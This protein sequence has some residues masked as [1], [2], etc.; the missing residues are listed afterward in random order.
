MAGRGTDIKLGEGVAANGGLHV[1]GTERHEARRID[2]QLRGRSGRQGDPGSTRFFVSFEDDLIRRF[3]P[4]MLPALLDRFGMEEDVPL[5]SK[6]VTRSIETAQGK[7]EA[8]NFDIRKNVVE[9]DD[10]M[11]THRDVIYQERDRVLTGDDMRDTVQTMVEEEIEALA[12]DH[13]GDVNVDAEAFAKAVESILP[14]DGA[15]SLDELETMGTDEASDRV[16]AL[17]EQRYDEMEEAMG[18]EAQRTLERYVLLSTIDALWVQHLTAMDEMR[19]GIGLRAYAQTDPLVA[20]KR[21]ARD[22]WDQLL[23]KIRSMV[24]RQIYHIRLAS[25]VRPQRQVAP[26]NVRESGPGE[27]STGGGVGSGEGEAAAAAPAATATRQRTVKKVGRNQACPCG[28]GKK[29]KRC[30]GRAA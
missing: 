30:H 18:E 19:Q 27:E 3:V 4:D 14:V 23:E 1:I 16:I 26:A 28:S 22:M 24:A 7:V 12:A 13:L 6:M 2:N 15:L 5:E 29:Y 25:A 17:A 21:E 11:N 8:Y 10:V 9:Y 20:Y